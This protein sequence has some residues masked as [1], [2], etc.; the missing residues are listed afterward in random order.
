MREIISE[1][2]IYSQ[3]KQ[4]GNLQIRVTLKYSLWGHRAPTSAFVGLHK[5]GRLAF[6]V[7]FRQCWV[8]SQLCVGNG[9][10]A[11]VSNIFAHQPP[12]GDGIGVWSPVAYE[13]I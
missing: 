8:S 1:Y 2:M 10:L 3:T 12:L 13:A 7:A 9:N 4:N 6:C 11:D 5:V